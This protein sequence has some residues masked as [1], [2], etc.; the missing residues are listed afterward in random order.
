MDKWVKASFTM[1]H[2]SEDE[3]QNMSD[4]LGL[5]LPANRPHQRGR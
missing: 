4:L 3:T 1:Y 5:K 2:S